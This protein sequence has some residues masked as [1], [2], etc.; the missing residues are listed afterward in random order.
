MYGQL[1]IVY[2]HLYRTTLHIALWSAAIQVVPIYICLYGVNARSTVFQFFLFF[3][4]YSTDTFRCMLV[5][6][7]RGAR[8]VYVQ[9]MFKRCLFIVQIITSCT[10]LAEGHWQHF[11]LEAVEGCTAD[12]CMG[13]AVPEPDGVWEEGSL[14]ALSSCERYQVVKSMSSDWADWSEMSSEDFN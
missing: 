2:K 5:L 14:V 7:Q 13:K 3:F 12:Y 1:S 10:G 11:P 6:T 4:R 8:N 9:V